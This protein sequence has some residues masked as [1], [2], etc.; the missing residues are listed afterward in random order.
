M[1]GSFANWIQT[2]SRYCCAQYLKENFNPCLCRD[3]IEAF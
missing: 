3:E 1:A 2:G